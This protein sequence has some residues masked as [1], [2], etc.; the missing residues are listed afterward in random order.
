MY[1][2]LPHFDANRFAA[3]VKARQDMTSRL[4]RQML[5]YRVRVEKD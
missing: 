5:Q 2:T 3:T 4:L 1:A